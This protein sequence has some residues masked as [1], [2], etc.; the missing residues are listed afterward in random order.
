METYYLLIVGILILLAISDLVVGV[1]NDA[2]N[3]LNSAIGS[4]VAPFRVIMIIAAVGILVGAT[5]SSGMM[6][7][8][9]KGIFHPDQFLFSE[10][11]I[12]FLAV[13]MTD[14][15]LLD[16]FNTMGLP[17]STTVSIV[18][19]L[20]GAAVGVA[21]LKIRA[22]G[23][24]TLSQYINSS[25]A[26]TIISGI[27][28][29]VVVA[30]TIGMIIMF[31]VRI[32]FSFRF[33]N[34]I[35]R[36]GA[37]WGGIA[38]STITFFIL[39]KGAKG[40]S[41]MTSETVDWI[42]QNT[43]L[44]LAASFIGWTVLLQLLYWIFRLNVLKMIVLVGTFALAMAFAGND[45]VN[46]IGVPLA[47]LES[48]VEAFR[49]GSVADPAGMAMAALK[50]PVRTPTV[51]LLIAGAVMVVALWTSKKA[52]S[53][54]AT[55]LNLGRQDEGHERFESSVLARGFVRSIVNMTSA[56]DS[57]T[58]RGLKKFIAGRFNQTDYAEQK[59]DAGLSFDLVRASVNLVTASALI[60]FATSLKLPL[61]TTYVT[62]MVAMGT[63]LA[64]GAWGRDSAV[65]RVSG[66]FTVI[67]GWFL[68][69]LTA[70]TVAFLIA[71]LI[72]WGGIYA[73]FILLG[74]SIFF[75]IKTHR[76]HRQ[77]NEDLKKAEE[78]SLIGEEIVNG[79]NVFKRCNKSVYKNLSA[80]SILYSNTITSLIG[81]K[82]QNAKMNL[83]E[84]AAINKEAKLLK[85]NL[86]QTIVKLQEDDIQT[87]HFYVQVLDYLRETAHCLR[88]IA[89]A[90]FEYIDNNHNPL[91][92]D[93]KSELQDFAHEVNLFFSDIIQV[94]KKA[95]Y[96]K[97]DDIFEDQSDLLNNLN[98][99]SNRQLKRIKKKDVGTKN[100]VLYLNTLNET[101]NLILF[102]VNLLKAQ[103]DFVQYTRSN[104]YQKK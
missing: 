94:I 34:N 28:L 11:M 5:F 71:N 53:V 29:S 60:S 37:I 12:V 81:M 102:C 93:Q 59:K 96:D 55:E 72:H 92:R 61:S 44:I 83:K 80:M 69:A 16:L 90:V 13:M 74:L 79:E 14:I 21:L 7:V 104:N 73:I 47:G 10:I 101:K 70:F 24:A 54:T 91:N 9:R 23:T 89:E 99:I 6:E 32:L 75:F 3:F 15:I 49:E 17:T 76:M 22:T 38:I 78:L 95:D 18:F 26:L 103:R 82:R 56:F 68:T 2:V 98:K 25:S 50:E 87:G 39:I 62:F 19:E 35:K 63:S 45:L 27:L 85:A 20:L 36:F 1:S 41:F 33:Q 65:Y 84:I 58:P 48:F 51:F 97:L 8:A 42:R 66:V 30:F 64:D 100:S 52:R 77:R 43:I 40:S 57:I 67:G 4:K 46:F 88:Y 86:H 31:L